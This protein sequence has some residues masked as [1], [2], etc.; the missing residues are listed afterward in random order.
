[1]K[2]MFI[3]IFVLLAIGLAFGQPAIADPNPPTSPLIFRLI[4]L[5]RG[6]VP[7]EFNSH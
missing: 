3:G 2:K 4:F 7:S 6:N 5:R 1:M